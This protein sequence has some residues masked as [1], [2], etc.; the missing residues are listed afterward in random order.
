MS[1]HYSQ[2][3]EA[4]FSVERYLAGLAL[5]RARLRNTRGKCY[6]PDSVTGCSA[7][8]RCGMTS[9][10][11]TG[12]HGAGLLTSS[13]AA[14]RARTSAPQGKEPDLT[15]NEA[16][17]GAKCSEWFARYDRSTSLWRTRHYLPGADLDVYL[18][19][20]PRQ[21]MMRRGYA[22]Q[23]PIVEPHMRENAYGC[24]GYSPEKKK[25]PE[26]AMRLENFSAIILNP[27]EK[28]LLMQ[29]NWWPTPTR[30]DSHKA[31]PSDL[32][33]REGGASLLQAVMKFPT[34]QV[35]DK[36]FAYKQTPESI[37]KRAERHQLNLAHVVQ[38]LPTP[39][40]Q[41]AK[42]NGSQSQK[43]RN[44]PPLNAVVGGALN[45]TWVEWLMGW[46]LGWTDLKRLETG[47]FQLWRQQHSACFTNN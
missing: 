43:E 20:W 45:P 46:P 42:N 23:L 39:T 47:K 34:P 7:S 21:G 31:H 29:R 30:H 40:C 22:C 3:R 18:A 1:W 35:A 32:Y 12:D 6:S 11:L 10:H 36:Q 5:E 33:G 27:T 13:A 37:A 2:E 26:K 16:G 38:L 8:S 14:F 17:C 41:D 9:G 28:D 44:T 15:E 4:A 19:A 24:L 25:E